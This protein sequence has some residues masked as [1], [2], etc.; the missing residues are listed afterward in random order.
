MQ[1]IT[2]EHFLAVKAVAISLKQYFHET[3]SKP[4]GPQSLDFILLCKGI[5]KVT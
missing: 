2:F 1:A 5:V 3:P 4:T